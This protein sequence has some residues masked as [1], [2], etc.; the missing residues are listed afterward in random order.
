STAMLRQTDSR[1]HTHS[2]ARGMEV[3]TVLFLGHGQPLEHQHNGPAGRANVDG[4]IGGVQGQNRS[5]HEQVFAGRRLRLM[6]GPLGMM[7]LM[8]L[9]SS[10]VAFMHGPVFLPIAT[11]LRPKLPG[12]LAV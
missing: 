4:F 8:A 3:V 9:V 10:L 7:M 2:D 5:L 1:G 12:I 6:P 11:P